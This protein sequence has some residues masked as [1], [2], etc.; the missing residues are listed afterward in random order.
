[1]WY[2][3][4]VQAFADEWFSQKE[5][6]KF[7]STYVPAG[8]PGDTQITY[9]GDTP[10]AAGG[11]GGEAQL[12]VDYMIGPAPGVGTEFWAYQGQEFCHGVFLLVFSS[13]SSLQT[14]LHIPTSLRA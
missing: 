3:R 7:V 10:P 12:D 2:A 14:I 6:D 1:M 13:S 9:V 5:L 8:R 4:G 11:G